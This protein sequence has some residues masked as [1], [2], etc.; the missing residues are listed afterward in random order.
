MIARLL[1]HKYEMEYRQRIGVADSG[2]A[3]N[4]GG[5]M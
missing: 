5:D 1:T 4:A 3:G 2:G